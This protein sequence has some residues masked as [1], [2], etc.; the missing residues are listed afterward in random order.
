MNCLY[1]KYCPNTALPYLPFAIFGKS[2]N[3]KFWRTDKLWGSRSIRILPVIHFWG[4]KS[5][6][7]KYRS[8][9]WTFTCF[10]LLHSQI[11][12]YWAATFAAK[13]FYHFQ[14]VLLDWKNPELE[15]RL[16]RSITYH[17][18]KKHPQ[19]IVNMAW[20][21]PLFSILLVGI[22]FWDL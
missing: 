20:S 17:N 11:V 13:K 19:G 22:L 21:H 18:W 15:N 9:K 4:L 14:K 5:P 10:S 3:G 12:A 16:G 7:I 6:Q 8:L 1:V 2:K